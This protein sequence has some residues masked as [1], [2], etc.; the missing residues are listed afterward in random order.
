MMYG[1]FDLAIDARHDR[2]S[3]AQRKP[4]GSDEE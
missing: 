4:L 3:W 1:F 2:R